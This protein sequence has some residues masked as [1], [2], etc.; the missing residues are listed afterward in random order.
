MNPTIEILER[1][2]LITPDRIR[3]YVNRL[4]LTGWN[5]LQ[6]QLKE[7]LKSEPEV[8]DPEPDLTPFNFMASSAIRGESGCST[9]KCRLEKVNMLARFAGLFCDRVVVPIHFHELDKK[10]DYYDRRFFST[11]LISLLELRPLVEHD[12]VRL[13]AGLDVCPVCTHHKLVTDDMLTASQ[14]IMDHYYPE[15][16]LSKI[17]SRGGDRL[18]LTGPE[19]FIEHG[20][21][22]P[23]P[24]YPFPIKGLRHGKLNHRF[25]Q[26]SHYVDKIFNRVIRETILQQLYGAQF[27]AKYLTSLP[28]EA[29]VLA[30]LQ[31]K[32]QLAEA[33][34]SL[35]AMLAH[36][37]PLLSEVPIETIIRIRREDHEV[38]VNYRSAFQKILKDYVVTKKRIGEAEAKGLFTDILEPEIRKMNVKASTERKSILKK[39]TAKVVFTSAA[40]CFGVHTGIVPTQM[41]AIIAALGGFSVIGN[42]AESLAA[43]NPASVRNENLYFLLRLK[44]EME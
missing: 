25:V 7:T 37:I 43:L 44:K 9:E 29:L 31:E 28:G 20:S 34:S 22:L 12:I 2:G 17:G 5:A 42:L 35:T 27:N 40:V 30:L 33:T 1:Y 6:E 10:P 14:R 13:V 39:S 26:K 18:L 3:E 24:P 16:S 8:I 41:A 11:S 4:D 38:F 21:I 19:E 32:D 23:N 36:K 15:F